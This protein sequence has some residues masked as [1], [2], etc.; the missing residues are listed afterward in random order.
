MNE[1]QE[2]IINTI[3]NLK[4]D[5][6]QVADS[7]WEHP[8]VGNEEFFA[9]DLLTGILR[10]KGF[11]ITRSLCDLPT[12]FKAE[13]PNGDVPRVALLA[14]Y[15]AL[16]EL[17]HACGH[18]LIAAAS[19]GAAVALAAIKEIEGSILV[20]GTPA[21]ETKGAKVLLANQ[22]VF[23]DVDVAMMFH[24][25]D[26][27]IV[28]IHSLAMD[29][30]EFVFEGKASHA[31]SSPEEGINALDAVIQFFNNINSLRLYLKDEANI[32]GIITEGGI[33]PNVTPERA[34]ARLYVR[35]RNRRK[36]DL[37]VKRVENCAS[38]AALLTGAHFWYRKYEPSYEAMKVSRTLA[39][40]WKNNISMLGVNNIKSVCYSRGSL[41]M[42][43]I[44]RVVPAIHPYLA[45][46][47]KK[48]APHTRDFAQA[49]KSK[50]GRETLIIATKALALT[51]A[52]VMLDNNLLKLIKKE[53]KD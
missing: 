12:A 19:F 4:E 15:D 3:E 52:D 47:S 9:V 30:L 44:S 14:E 34:V 20:I 40:V 21:E 10:D 25:S 50:A 33:T 24:P 1:I 53:F 16:P 18:N 38:A 7:I 35:A 39:A 31:S 29:A 42:G 17:G 46:N 11:E 51:A 22:G 43:N 27:N 28:E 32:N 41:D 2:K 23:D 49:V 6:F 13:F 5:I 26:T 37:V 36:L 48:I 8:E 45:I